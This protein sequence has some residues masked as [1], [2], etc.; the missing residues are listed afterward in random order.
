MLSFS[1]DTKGKERKNDN[2]S[3]P[4]VGSNNLSL[5]SIDN[6][7]TPK[8]SFS[9]LP[10]GIDKSIRQNPLKQRT[11][12]L[13]PQSEKS[14]D[15]NR[16][17]VK[18]FANSHSLNYLSLISERDGYDLQNKSYSDYKDFYRKQTERSLQEEE[19]KKV[20]LIINSFGGSVGNGITVHDALQF[21]KAG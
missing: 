13:L 2:I 8:G 3:Q 19:S 14:D 15:R 12:L 5:P 21:I 7:G 18:N 11:S 1:I 16:R 9:L 6:K 4:M 20:F 10:F 17:T